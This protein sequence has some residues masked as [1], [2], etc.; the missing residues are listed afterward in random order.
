M[1]MV[2]ELRP[3]QVEIAR[4]IVRSVVEG[5]GL[6]FSVKVSRQGG[7]NEVSALIEAYLLLKSRET[8]GEIVKTAPT[9]EP[10][11]GDLEAEADQQAGR[12][13]CR[14]AVQGGW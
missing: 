11:A 10:A 13:G 8:G 4:A 6:T 7:K 2:V 12:G 5:R 1:W 14:R 3:Y 9:L